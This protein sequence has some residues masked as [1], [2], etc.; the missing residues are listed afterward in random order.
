MYALVCKTAVVDTVFFWKVLNNHVN[1][2]FLGFCLQ[3]D[4]EMVLNSGMPLHA[5]HAALPI[6][7]C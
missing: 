7:N 3:V 1:E 6:L 5:S 4:A 2:S